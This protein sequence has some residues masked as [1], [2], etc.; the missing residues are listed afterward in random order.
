MDSINFIEKLRGGFKK[1]LKEFYIDQQIMQRLVNEGQSPK[2]IFFG[3]M[4]S[5]NTLASIFNLKP[6]DVFI[7]KGIGNIHPKYNENDT[8][9]MKLSAELSLAIDQFKVKD[10][11]TTSHTNCGATAILSKQNNDKS[12]ISDWLKIVGKDILEKSLQDSINNKTPLTQIIE[13]NIVKSNYQRLI[14]YPSV[15][16]AISEN[17]INIHP[18]LFN[19]KKG[20]ISEY[21]VKTDEFEIISGFDLNELESEIKH[22]TCCGVKNITDNDK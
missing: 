20:Q 5:R 12:I 8:S 4:D 11:F 16:D 18:W 19:M 9:S 22:S 10:I 17:R 1:Y 3:C 13:R 6:N 15:K 7:V 21:N 2:A 14:E